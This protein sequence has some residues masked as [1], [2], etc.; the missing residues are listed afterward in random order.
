MP[1]IALKT[2]AH[3]GAGIV[4][5]GAEKA[6]RSVRSGGRRFTRIYRRQWNGGSF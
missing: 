4:K 3:D 1:N 5:L 6:A 2:D